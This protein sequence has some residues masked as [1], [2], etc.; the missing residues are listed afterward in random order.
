M[1]S[2]QLTVSVAIQ[3]IFMKIKNKFTVLWHDIWIAG[4]A[5]PT[6][7]ICII[8]ATKASKSIKIMLSQLNMW[9][10]GS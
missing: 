2:S 6:C 4:G 7:S 1:D 8:S 9:V 5:S 10:N 3:I